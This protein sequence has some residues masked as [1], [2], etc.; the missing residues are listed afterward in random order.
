MPSSSSS[1]SP[2]VGS[3]AKGRPHENSSSRRTARPSPPPSKIQTKRS[4]AF[5]RWA[6]GRCY[7]C[8]AYGHQVGS[9]KEFFRCIRCHQ[10]GH[11]ERHCPFR[12]SVAA[13]SC[14]QPPIQA[15]HSQHTHTCADVVAMSPSNGPCG[16]LPASTMGNT[17]GVA[18]SACGCLCHAAKGSHTSVELLLE[19]L[20]SDLQEFIGSRLEEA[21]RPL[22]I[23]A[24]TIKLWLARVANHLEHVEPLCEDPLV[25]LFG[26]CSP[27]RRSPT[28]ALFTSLSAACKTAEHSLPHSEISM[29]VEDIGGQKFSEA[30]LMDVMPTT[31]EEELHA[32]DSS[33]EC[34]A[35][36]DL[37]NLLDATSSLPSKVQEYEE[38][39][40]EH[41]L[42]QVG[43]DVT[44]AKQ[45]VS[46]DCVLPNL[47]IIREIVVATTPLLATT[48]AG[49]EQPEVT[50][51]DMTMERMTQQVGTSFEDVVVVEDASDDEE[52]LLGIGTPIENPIFLITIEDDPIHSMDEVKAEEAQ[53]IEGPSLEIVPPL[54]TISTNDKYL[55]CPSIRPPSPPSMTARRQ[56]KSY[57]RS[58]LRR[59]ARL[60]QRS[61]LKDLG[62]LRD[63][64]SLNEDVIQDYADRLKKLLP[65]D[66]LKPLKS[67]KGRAFLDLLVEVSCFL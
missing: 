59:S 66:R 2:R 21:V 8:L 30:N 32:T 1:G 46:K 44:I 52:T 6:R 48:I 12:F 18:C 58:S 53:L 54:A 13:P 34:V 36:E 42:L 39:S 9:C 43:T 20:C 31:T 40:L 11:K 50:L 14:H 38:P 26:P 5:K 64:C 28:P 27:V 51:L 62:I 19:S 23:E 17:N 35:V 15:C 7:H 4:L 56:R 55:G 61:V 16:T 47:P 60:A 22:K 67:L 37:T 24:S 65:P 57:D 10:C 33:F 3:Q 41:T 63:D 45:S 49:C 25:G 29:V